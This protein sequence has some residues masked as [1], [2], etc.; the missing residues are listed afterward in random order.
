MTDTDIQADPSSNNS[1]STVKMPVE[2]SLIAGVA[3]LSFLLTLFAFLPALG[4]RF[5]LDEQFIAA[6]SKSLLSGSAAGGWA[7]YLSWT[8]ADAQDAFGPIASLS[9][10]FFSQLGASLARLSSMVVHAGCSMALYLV[11]RKLTA[12]FDAKISIFIS[13]FAALIFA[14]HPLSA[15][16]I[17]FVGASGIELSVLFFALSFNFYLSAHPV[18]NAGSQSTARKNSILSIVFFVCAYLAYAKSWYLLKIIAMFEVLNFAL[19]PVARSAY[20]SL[21]KDASTPGRKRFFITAGSLMAASVAF[22]TVEFARGADPIGSI[23]AMMPNGLK[24]MLLA[25][26]FPINRSLWKKY[27]L[28]YIV[29][30]IVFGLAAALSAYGVWR[31][32]KYRV[33]LATATA[34]VF[35]GL[36]VGGNQSLVA[37]DFYGHRYLAHAQAGVCILLPMLCFGLASALNQKRL[38]AAAPGALVCLLFMIT[39]CRHSFAQ[40]QHYKNAGK[41]L[42]K[43]QKSAAIICAKEKSPYCIAKDVPRQIAFV[44]FISP[45]RP[46]LLDAKNGLMRAPTVSGGPLKDAL[47]AGRLTGST[48]RWDATFDSLVPAVVEP[49]VN[50]PAFALS[51]EKL[52]EALNPPL[53]FWKTVSLDKQEESLKVSS[54]SEHEPGISMFSRVLSP[55]DGDAFYIDAKIST[56]VQ[57]ANSNV[58]LH[59]MTL[60]TNNYEKEDRRALVLAQLNDNAY[61][62]YLLSLRG[63]GWTTNGPPTQITLGFPSSSTVDIKGV[64]IVNDKSIFAKFK[65]AGAGKNTAAS[66][67]CDLC[68]DY[69]DDAD[70]GLVQINK[71]SN[72]IEFTYDVSAIA[73]GAGAI[74]FSSQANQLKVLG[75][76]GEIPQDS[77]FKLDLKATSGTVKI[78]LDQFAKTGIYGLRIAALDATGKP[79]GIFSD[80][81]WLLVDK[82][83]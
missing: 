17:N 56:P 83:Q 18:W 28:E 51:A 22:M 33:A 7:S 81:V 13:I 57:P 41:L 27:S 11:S 66:R 77:A 24:N 46:L 68:F 6:W 64:G 9:C 65:S 37:D 19:D 62:R 29:L 79:V 20:K 38:W 26:M 8:G 58:E 67:F 12:D 1:H 39:S 80:R 78:A 47:A 16:L 3:V 76:S 69:P 59:W 34:W 53:Q 43:I 61:H 42:E 25:T 44:P 5:L 4:S 23:L 15:E 63:T 72:E 10:V 30:Y 54:N 71:S 70:L 82:T 74:L 50:Q 52:G 32:P 73:G 40:S 35:F 75:D 48:T 60:H 55:I 21:F 14:V 45:Y 2:R 49:K 31:H 36:L